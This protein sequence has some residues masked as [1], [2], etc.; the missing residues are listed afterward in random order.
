MRRE[1]TDNDGRRRHLAIDRRGFLWRTGALAAAGFGATVSA[2]A[3]DWDRWPNEQVDSKEHFRPWEPSPDPEHLIRSG[4]GWR[5]LPT[6]HDDHDNLEWALRNTESGGTVWLVPGTYK[7]GSPILVPD[8]NGRLVGAGAKRTTITCTD[9]FSYELW[10]AP[11]GGRDRNEPPPP[12]FPRRPIEGAT[13]RSAPVLINFYKTPLR[14]GERPERR[15]NRIE[16]HNIRC[17]GAMKGEL[18]ALGDEVLCINIVNS[19][20]WRHPESAPATTRQDVLISGLEVDGYST[21][22]FGP[23]ENARASPFSAARS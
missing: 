3:Q 8:F 4:R 22:S 7:I 18:W 13:T 16:I 21:P 12:P 6:G 15:A 14:R 10:E 23:F 20:D 1:A 9:E 17:R 5:V 2:N 11:G 19:V